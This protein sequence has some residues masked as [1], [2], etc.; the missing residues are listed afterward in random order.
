MTKAITSHDE[1]HLLRL[2]SKRSDRLKYQETK[3]T[4]QSGEWLIK[5]PSIKKKLIRS[6][7]EKVLII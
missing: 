1:R 5:V 6:I 7:K 4:T 3:M 2:L